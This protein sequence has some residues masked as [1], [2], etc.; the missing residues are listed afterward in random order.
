[1]VLE[2]TH[3]CDIQSWHRG[4]THCEFCGD[5]LRQKSVTGKCKGITYNLLCPGCKTKY[6]LSYFK[7]KDFGT[8]YDLG[9]VTIERGN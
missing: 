9:D 3:S 8:V 2:K 4:Y 1:M 7:E 5:A 6:V